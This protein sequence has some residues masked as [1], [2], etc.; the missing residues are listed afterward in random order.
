MPLRDVLVERVFVRAAAV[1][2]AV[3]HLEIDDPRRALAGIIISRRPLVDVRGV[4]R[5]DEL[6]PVVIGRMGGEAF[7]HF[8]A[9]RDFVDHSITHGLDTYGG[10]LVVPF[11]VEAG[12]AGR[13]KGFRDNASGMEREAQ[14]ESKKC[15]NEGL[16]WFENNMKL[17]VRVKR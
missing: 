7:Q 15:R 10:A 4:E 8:V 5:L 11:D 13:W 3:F 1:E 16:H 6:E 14:N 2:F 17:T 9:E 12:E